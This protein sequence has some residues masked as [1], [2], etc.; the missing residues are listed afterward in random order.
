MIDLSICIPTLNAS[1]YLRSCLVSIRAQPGLSWLETSSDE[2]SQHSVDT[3]DAN[4]RLTAEVIVV[5]NAS[6]DDTLDMLAVEFPAARLVKNSRNLGF[7][8]PV[9]QAL[10]VSQ[11]RYML[12]L[13]PDT[14]VL[15]GAINALVD[16][17][18]THPEVGI[19]GPKV[20]NRD[21][22]L[23]KACKR[24]VSRPWAAFSYFSGLSALFP[25]SKFFGGYLLNY[26]D[27]DEIHEVDG[28]SGS[29][30][31]IRR[32]VLD[33]VGFLDEVFFAYQEDA[34]YCFQVKKAGWKVVYLPVAQ[35]IHFGGQGG[36]RAQPYKSI[37]E[38]HR[39]YYLYYR[40][41][42]ASDYF[43]LFN[44]FYYGLMGVKLL[45]SLV[46]NALRSN[47]YAGPRRS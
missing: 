40:K 5:D 29:C 20:L 30:M 21:G 23:Q 9:N 35:I 2:S 15:P 43:F 10:Q 27:E 26:L 45:I 14:I 37:F 7:T 31:L 18:E 39:S 46:A 32:S 22:T 13:N 4:K 33:Q 41:N 17:M 36:S 1:A 28:I 34:D 47:K 12:L 38:W 44:W 19:C 42:L 6:T 3:P 8:R 16:Y 25:R 11:G 24:G